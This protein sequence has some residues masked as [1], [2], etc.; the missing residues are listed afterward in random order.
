[1]KKTLHLAALVATIFVTTTVSAQVQNQRCG[2][3]EEDR[4]IIVEQLL[5]NKAIL[6]SRGGT[7]ET[8]AVIYV[9]IIFHLVA[10]SD[11]TGRLPESNVMSQLCAL[12]EY[13]REQEIQFYLRPAEG[14]NPPGINYINNDGM[15]DTPRGSFGITLAVQNKKYDA[16]NIYVVNNATASGGGPG[17]TL[18]YYSNSF[19][20]AAYSADWIVSIKSQ[21]GGDAA[22]LAHEMGHFFTLPHTHN[23]WDAGPLAFSATRAPTVSPGGVTTENVARDNCGA[24]GDYLCDTPADYNGLNA[25]VSG[26]ACAA[27]QNWYDPNGTQLKANNN[28]M[29]YFSGCTSYVFS[30]QQKTMIRTDLTTNANRSYIR[31]NVT[32]SLLGATA[33]PTLISPL[34]GAVQPFYNYVQLSWNAVPNAQGYIVE[35]SLYQTFDIGLISFFSPTS[36]F[37]VDNALIRAGQTPM[38]ANRN[39]YWR[40][41][42]FTAY[43]S[44]A[45]GCTQYSATG[46]FRTGTA[47]GTQE[48]EGVKTFNVSPNPI[49]RGQAFNVEISMKSSLDATVRLTDIAGKTIRSEKRTFAAGINRFDWR[50]EDLSAGMYVLSIEGAEGIVSKK[51]VVMN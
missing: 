3:N 51:V 1:M 25:P 33:V 46:L 42:P 36:N 2:L 7:L 21:I 16:M 10:K 29:S 26:T 18:A 14:G 30:A 24:A 8:R 44:V 20:G 13:Y 40:V 15:Y 23:G 39:Y 41:R 47:V 34:G 19:N 28:V 38:L 4:Q 43:N 12:N 35:V 45:T 48:L 9:P 32:P 5:R 11:G 31:R 22:T 6:A 37:G 27:N 49:D 50:I 17:T